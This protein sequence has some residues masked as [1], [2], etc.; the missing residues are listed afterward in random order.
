MKTIDIEGVKFTAQRTMRGLRIFLT[1]SDGK[2]EITVSERWLRDNLKVLDKIQKA[3]RFIPG[4]ILVSAYAGR[5]RS[6]IEEELA[7]TP[8]PESPESH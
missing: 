2:A 1:G 3:A 4:S 5:L 6:A 7:V 8:A